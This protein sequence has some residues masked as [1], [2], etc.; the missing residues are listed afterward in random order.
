[1]LQVQHFFGGLGRLFGP[2]HTVILERDDESIILGNAVGKA[3]E[4]SDSH[5]FS[6]LCVGFRP[7]P[8]HTDRAFEN[9]RNIPQALAPRG[10]KG[11]FQ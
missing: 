9:R 7:R 5:N 4:G 11:D 3:L 8:R 6:Q 1:M 2:S 10:M